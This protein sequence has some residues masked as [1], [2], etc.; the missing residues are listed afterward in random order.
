[1]AGSGAAAALDVAG[2]GGLGVRGLG[3]GG[4]PGDP[5]AIGAIGTRGRPVDISLRS[6]HCGGCGGPNVAPIVVDGTDVTGALDPELVRAVIRSH[7][8]QIR[9]CYEQELARDPSLSGKLVVKLIIGHEGLVASSQVVDSTV[10][11]EGVERCVN[12]RVQSWV[13]PKPKG[14]GVVVVRYP[15]VLTQSGS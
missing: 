5:Y 14:G 13:F 4:S 1:L 15:F 10:R 12:S 2:F 8:D 6:R 7:R 3:T 11:N 9:Y